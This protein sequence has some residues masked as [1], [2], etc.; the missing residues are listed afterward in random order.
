MNVLICGSMPFS[1]EVIKKYKKNYYIIA[2]DGGYDHLIEEG[3]TPDLLIGDFDSIDSKEILCKTI[4]YESEKDF[5]DLE[6]AIDYSVSN[7]SGNID[8]IG[9]TG[10]RIDHFLSAIFLLRKSERLRIIDKNNTCFYRNGSFELKKQEEC[11]FGIFPINKSII[12]IKGAKYNIESEEVSLFNS[13]LIS[14]E[15][16]E[17][18]EIVSDGESIVVITKK[19]PR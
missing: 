12:S 8:I 11:Y 2:V 9:V 13:R 7:F 1:E 19:I 18:V 16:M 5:S 17:D 14:N 10:G 4:K 15:F 6:A 3:I